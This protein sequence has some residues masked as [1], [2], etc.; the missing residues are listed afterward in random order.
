MKQQFMLRGIIDR[1]STLGIEMKQQGDGVGR[2]RDQFAY[3]RSIDDVTNILKGLT[4]N[5]QEHVS[6]ILISKHQLFDNLNR[7]WRGPDYCL[8]VSKVNQ[9]VEHAAAHGHRRGL[10]QTLT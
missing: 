8:G 4:S 10:G 6:F 2:A 3:K 1:I 7:C 9:E 5:L